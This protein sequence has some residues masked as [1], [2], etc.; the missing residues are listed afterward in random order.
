MNITLFGGVWIILLIFSFFFNTKYILGLTL[1]SMV[2]QCNNILYIGETGI[3]V[4]IFTVCVACL[5]VLLTYPTSTKKNCTTQKVGFALFGFIFFMV[6]S[7]LI[8]GWQSSAWISLVI[9]SV[10]ALFAYLLISRQIS[11]DNKWLEKVVDFIIIFVLI[12]G[13]IQ[14]LCVYNVLPIRSLLKTLIYN[15]TNNS[16]VIF[17]YK[18]DHRAFYSTFMEP[19]FCGAFLV[20]C[21]AYLILKGN[22]NRKNI[23]LIISVSLAILFTKS[24]TAYGGLFICVILLLFLRNEKKI[25]K[26]LLPAIG[27][28][29]LIVFTVFNNVVNEVIFDKINTSSYTVRGNWND[30]ALETFKNN[31]ILGIGYG[32]IRA[33]GLIHTMLGATG[34]LGLISYLRLVRF[35]VFTLFKERKASECLSCSFFV[36]GIIICQIIACP[37]LN[38]S[39]FWLGIFIFFISVNIRQRNVLE[40]NK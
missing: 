24:S 3:G 31:V 32:N 13:V 21:F 38:F 8:N 20:G 37:D 14:V 16:D 15:D 22:L 27:L 28:S 7:V 35:P 4:Q 18:I 17:N 33:S 2:L 25:F 10:Y 34:L 6:L 30:A 9:L 23:F 11:F 29:A 5:K 1:F 19:S 40:E 39:A 36:V 12:I 26:F